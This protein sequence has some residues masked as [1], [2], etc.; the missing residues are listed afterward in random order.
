MPRATP[1]RIKAVPVPST[2]W[3]SRSALATAVCR[4]LRLRDTRA[5]RLVLMASPQTLRRLHLSIACVFI[6]CSLCPSTRATG[7][8]PDGGS[9]TDSL[10]EVRLTGAAAAAA[11][12]AYVAIVPAHEPWREPLLERALGADR[13]TVGW[14]VPPGEYRVVCGVRGFWWHHTDGIEVAGGEDLVVPCEP[15]ATVPLK[16]R[17]SAAASAQPIR[18]ARIGHLHGFLSDFPL[19][20]SPLGQELTSPGTVVVSGEDGRFE[21]RGPQAGRVPLWIEADGFSPRLVPWLSFSDPPPEVGN[22]SLGP[23]S[24]LS[25]TIPPPPAAMRSRYRITLQPLSSVEGIVSPKSFPGVEP[26]LRALW[27]R[28]I[29]ADGHIGWSALPPIRFRVLATGVPGSSRNDFPI[30]VGE[31]DL[32]PGLP[33][34][35][36]AAPEWPEAEPNSVGT[37][38]VD[39]FELLL[40]A[41]TPLD[42]LSVEGWWRND[43]LDPQFRTERVS[44]GILLAVSTGCRRDSTYVIRTPR[45]VSAPLV[46]G[47]ECD[48]PRSV[49][50]L[51]ASVLAGALKAPMRSGLP[52]MARL[53]VASCV[54]ERRDSEVPVGGSYPL[55]IAPSPRGTWEVPVPAGCL[56]AIL[57]VSDYAPLRLPRLE[58]KAGERLDVGAHQLYPGASLIARVVLDEADEPIEG[59]T[60]SLIADA[61]V[62]GAVRSLFAQEPVQAVVEARTDAGGWVRLYGLPPGIFH[63]AVNSQQGAPYFSEPIELMPATETLVDDLRIPLPASIEL[64]V[65]MDA[66]A[67][68]HLH[69]LSVHASPMGRSHWT[70][71]AEIHVPVDENDRVQIDGLPPGEWNLSLVGRLSSGRRSLVANESVSL[72]AG[73][74]QQ[75]FLRADVSL[76]RGDLTHAG[77]G[78]GAALEFRQKSGGRQRLGVFSTEEGTWEALL[79]PGTYDV[80]FRA[81]EAPLTGVIPEVEL[82]DSAEFYS[83]EVPNGTIEGTV[84]DDLGKA[85]AGA[86]VSADGFQALRQG[87]APNEPRH[88]GQLGARTDDSGSFR[89]EGLAPGTWQLWAG[90]AD[91]STPGSESS[92]VPVEL[93]GDEVVTGVR[94]ILREGEEFSGTVLS[95][96]GLPVAGATGLV[97]HASPFARGAPET[98]SFTSGPDGRF[99]VALRSQPGELV[100]LAAAVRGVAA[101]AARTALSEA[102]EARLPSAVGEV[103][104]ELET[105]SW[106]SVPLSRYLLVSERSGFL[107]LSLLE[108][109]GL[110]TASTDFLAI[111]GLAPGRWRI[112]S[113]DS[114]DVFQ[115]ITLGSLPAGRELAT[116]D[117]RSYEISYLKIARLQPEEIFE[118]H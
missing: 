108:R 42:E 75:V 30:E 14:R 105:G 116:F 16:G 80:V 81:R 10:V 41:D 55:A 89:F 45:D 4:L 26:L 98:A 12:P 38:G 76:F 91:S 82:T 39:D 48:L 71:S 97:T 29:P 11:A 50:L 86:R 69:D 25:L 110:V 37:K 49:R 58:L 36:S 96:Q 83:L 65:Q 111:R 17:I 94:L 40:P 104:I 84:L 107:H 70:A 78:V 92:R 101:V 93:G 54:S 15:L 3:A 27:Q 6:L 59:A 13:R 114:P 51:P 85:V 32:Q 77:E 109:A 5:V 74:P 115:A 7:T 1:S 9:E 64:W 106:S 117:V 113:V 8:V 43:R 118:V 61:D 57:A 79:E 20:L 47:S 52:V 31:V 24:S 90:P 87:Q 35:L 72:Q 66:A 62:A 63:L 2:A 56:D 100:N 68:V 99:K 112:V 60:V 67:R 102:I 46:V 21:L 88:L 73:R 95:A 28:P 34:S 53:A 33:A 19:M 23:G 44:G 22:I 18:G 103:R